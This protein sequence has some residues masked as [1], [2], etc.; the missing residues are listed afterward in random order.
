[1][2]PNGGK[3]TIATRNVTE[4][5]SQ[6]MSGVAGFTP[7]EYVLI[8]VADTGS[9]MSPEVMSKIFEPFF[10]TKGVGKGTGLGLASVYGIIKQSGGF[11]LPESELGVGTTFKVFLP[12]YFVEDS[13]D[14]ETSLP[15]TIAAAKKELK[16][17]DLTGT[18][19]VLL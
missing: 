5:E 11:I 4:R 17:T 1:A 13:D 10:T 18:G 9:G 12:R 6:N 3:I 15:L 16:A 19:R 14:V 7:G 2:M 8:E